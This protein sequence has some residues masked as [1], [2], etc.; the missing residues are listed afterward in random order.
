[1]TSAD[2][3]LIS[4]IVGK[5]RVAARIFVTGEVAEEYIG[6]AATRLLVNINDVFY[7]NG[8]GV[9][10]LFV[11]TRADTVRM[12]RFDPAFVWRCFHPDILADLVQAE[13]SRLGVDMDPWK[14]DSMDFY[15]SMVDFLRKKEGDMAVP[16]AV[17]IGGIDEFYNAVYLSCLLLFDKPGYMA[18]SV[19]EHFAPPKTA[20]FVRLA[21]F[22][23]LNQGE[24]GRMRE[25]R[26]KYK[27]IQALT[28][29]EMD[30]VV[31]LYDRRVK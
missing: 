4:T 27:D 18:V 12:T 9:E 23:L 19:A 25:L 15:A 11:Q 20:D 17:E 7:Q 21:G 26:E 10:P 29:P 1:M 3:A 13:I 14:M 8:A 16:L 30:F 2:K 6:D 5:N 31:D 28:N 22:R 24:Q